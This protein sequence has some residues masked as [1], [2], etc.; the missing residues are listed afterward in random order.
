MKII[1][2]SKY[3]HLREYLKNL[4]YHFMHDGKEIFRDRNVV[5]TLEVDGL[6]LCV[7][8]Y[9]SPSLP[10]KIAQRLYK[11][12]K[13][14]KAYY[15]P[16]QLRERGI[17]SPE[18]VAFVKYRKGFVSATTYFVSL[19]SDYRYNMVDALSLPASERDDLI[20]A[21]ARFAARLHERGFLH[22]DFSSSNILYDVVGGKYRFALIDTNSIRTG[23]PINV[24]RG[25]KNLAQLAGDDEFFNKL[26]KAYAEVRGEDALTCIEI[27]QKMWKKK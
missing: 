6:K 16:L 8:K 14:K 1:L 25:C 24:E 10:G 3:E 19:Y 9:A 27:I 15:R 2:N 7:K 18:P 20:V 21:F 17:D 12:P 22:R 26:A 23:R 5:K 11:T 4:E 13:G